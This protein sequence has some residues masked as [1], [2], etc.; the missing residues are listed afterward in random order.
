MYCRQA[1]Q[2]KGAVRGARKTKKGCRS[3]NIKSRFQYQSNS[4]SNQLHTNSLVTC[5]MG[6]IDPTQ[7]K[8]PWIET[9][10]IESAALS[11]AAGW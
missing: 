10:L 9:P 8:K 2:R 7:G 4:T 5:K 1:C 3:N 6:H 11:K